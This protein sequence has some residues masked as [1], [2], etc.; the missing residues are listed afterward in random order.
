MARIT[1]E[2]VEVDESVIEG[3]EVSL[4]SVKLISDP[5]LR[6]K[7]KVA[8]GL[9]LTLGGFT[10]VE[11]MPGSARPGAPIFGNQAQ[12]MEGTAKIALGIKRGLE[13]VFNEEIDVSDDIL[14]AS[15]LCH[16]L[17]KP[18]EY[19]EAN[20]ARWGK[21]EIDTGWP[22]VRHPAYGAH[23]ALVVGLPESVVHVAAAHAAE[24]R[25]VKVS[26][27]A[28][29]VQHADDAYWFTIDRWQG[30]VDSGLAL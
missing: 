12:H 30:W 17:G 26:L 11:D 1:S 27:P 5:E 15:A 9:A 6:Q 16:D 22:S 19:S 29:I 14:I 25:L 2:P 7:V 21:D 4:P 13:E 18:H 20:R 24:G 10:K 28:R 8:W 3:V 23:I